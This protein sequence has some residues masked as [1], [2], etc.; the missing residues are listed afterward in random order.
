MIRESKLGQWYLTWVE[1][2]PISILAQTSLKPNHLTYLGFIAGLLT[3]PAYGYT[4]WLGGLAVLVS[5]FIDTLDGSL[6]R[7]T[8]QKTKSGA[9]LDSVFDRYSDFSIV[10]GIWVYYRLHSHPWPSLIVLILFLFLSGSFLVSY[11][12]ARGEGLGVS[13]Q[14][15]LF[16]RGERVV[17]LGLGS[18]I[19]DLLMAFFPVVPGFPDGIL[20]FLL[21][22]LALGTHL[23]ALQRII[24]LS[25]RL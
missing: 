18:I 11:A 14:L 24:Y 10:L 9:F 17:V 21:I 8:G 23:T 15:G 1:R 16:S 25:K 4:L 2:V 6:A 19:N 7:K 12:R 5:G 13:A 20:W 3:I 22:L